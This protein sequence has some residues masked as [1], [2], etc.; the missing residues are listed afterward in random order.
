[1]VQDTALTAGGLFTE[2]EK[3]LHINVKE[4]LAILFS[5]K[6]F[7]KLDHYTHIKVMT[8]NMTAVSYVREMGGGAPIPQ[9]VMML[10]V[11]FGSGQK[12]RTFG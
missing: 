3:Q 2:N 9:R 1:M 7:C 12:K 4:M 6:S 8:N 11:T 10:P 5:L